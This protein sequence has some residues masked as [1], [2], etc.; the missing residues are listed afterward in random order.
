MA[1]RFTRGEVWRGRRPLQTSPLGRGEDAP[2]PQTARFASTKV[3]VIIRRS[4]VDRLVDIQVTFVDLQVEPTARVRAYPRLVRH[5][6]T[7]RAVIREW[8]ELALTALSTLW[9]CCYYHRMFSSQVAPRPC[10]YLAI[11]AGSSRQGSQHAFNRCVSPRNFRARNSST[12]EDQRAQK[13]APPLT[14]GPLQCSK[15]PIITRL[16]C[17]LYRSMEAGEGQLPSRPCGSSSRNNCAIDRL[18][19]GAACAHA[20]EIVV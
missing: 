17:L 6:R 15:I 3:L 9:P 19:P 1:I 12:R 5:R 16:L 4:L 18:A 20:A 11:A 2:T 13:P 10:A 7:F 8:D 14:T